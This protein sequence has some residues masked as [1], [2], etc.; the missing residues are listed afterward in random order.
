MAGEECEALGVLF[1]EHLA[2][3]S[4]SETNLAAVSYGSRDTEGLKSL[5]DSG[6][7]LS[8]RAAVLLDCDCCAY[9]V[10]PFCVLKADRLNAL[11]L[12]VYIKTCG[13]CYLCSFFNR[14]DPVLSKLCEN[15]FF[16]SFI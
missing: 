5:T 9:G 14:V 11:D 4:M 15:L 6:S 10:S 16:S 12:M 8:G 7:S 3:V 2:K 1:Q 13:L